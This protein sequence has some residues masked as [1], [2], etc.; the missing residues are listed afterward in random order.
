MKN[1]G[2][3]EGERKVGGWVD[4]TVITPK[5]RP[6]KS[7]SWMTAK[8]PGEHQTIYA[9]EQ[10]SP[11]PLIERKEVGKE[12]SSPLI[13]NSPASCAVATIGGRQWRT[14]GAA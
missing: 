2:K 1:E 9:P 5:L 13:P 14:E 8:R 11:S 7:G 10:H 12:A 3:R 4:A 6:T